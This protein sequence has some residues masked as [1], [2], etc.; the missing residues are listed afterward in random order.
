MK[1]IFNFARLDVVIM[2][3]MRTNKFY[4]EPWS[5]CVIKG[6]RWNGDLSGPTDPLCKN[7]DWPL[8]KL[9]KL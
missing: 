4:K 3:H 7:K 6:H 9:K 2:N 5:I 8:Y 1:L